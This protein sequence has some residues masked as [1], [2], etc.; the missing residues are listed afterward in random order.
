MVHRGSSQPLP[1]LPL[2]LCA[3]LGFL[4]CT[5]T[6]VAQTKA[7]APPGPSE[8]G[9]PLST[10]PQ[11]AVGLRAGVSTENYEWGHEYY[12]KIFGGVSATYAWRPWLAVG[13][14]IEWLSAY[15]PGELFMRGLCER[16]VRSGTQVLAVGELR[17]KL[18]IDALKLF[19]RVSAGPAFVE[20]VD[21]DSS[22]IASIR[23]SAGLE[24]SLW[25]V[26]VRPFGFVASLVT[27][28]TQPGAG[29]EVGALF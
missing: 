17:T 21:G 5:T 18:G 15:G 10:H 4:S 24:L 1:K 23:A 22:V 11:F 12:S 25:H 9:R 26:Y 7:A 14:E 2:Q 8:S 3:L 28:S 27:Q 19:G 6:A 13:T 16:C 29:L 20:W